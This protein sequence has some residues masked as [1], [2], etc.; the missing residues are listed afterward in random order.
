MKH[1]E[2]FVQ[3][4]IVQ[5]K[6]SRYLSLLAS[7]KRRTVFLDRLNHNLD[8]DSAFAVLVPSNQQSAEEIEKLLRKQGAQN[9]CHLISAKPEWDAQDMPLRKALDLVVG[10][11]IG[12]VLCCIP[13]RLAYYESEDLGRRFILSK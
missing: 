2:A 11:N 3:A 5:D 13:G 7:Q 4:F 12:T 1:E 9:T 8:F 6:Q 10:I